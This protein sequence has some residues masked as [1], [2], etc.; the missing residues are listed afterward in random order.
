MQRQGQLNVTQN[1]ELRGKIG[2]RFFVA[3]TDENWFGFLR[4]L[5]PEEVNFWRPGSA[6]FSAVPTGAPFLFKLHSRRGRPGPIVGGGFFVRYSRLPVSLAWDAFGERNGAPD[7]PTFREQLRRH[8][9]ADQR[10]QPDPVIGCVILVD[11]FFF[12]DDDFVPAPDDWA[13]NIVQGKSYGSDE[14]TGRRLWEG[15]QK[16]LASGDRVRGEG[17]GPPARTGADYLSR[18]RLGQG[19]FRVVTLENYRR[20]CS[21]TAETTLP[22]LQAAHIKPIAEG[23][24]HSPRNGLLL[25]ADLHILFDQG[26]LGVTPDYRVQVSN[27]IRDDYLNGRVYYEH[28]NRPLRSLPQDA[29]LRPDPLALQWHMDEKFVR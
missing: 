3:I 18:A 2:M 20:R 13:P 27:R 19:A 15:V 29:A 5:R 11:P 22:V 17:L 10:Q 25:R 21:I 12:A 28:H 6:G 14:P 7:F 8:W 1:R 16:R 23:G 9:T 24:S 4:D 26:L